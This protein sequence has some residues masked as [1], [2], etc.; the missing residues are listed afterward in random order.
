MFTVR[1]KRKKEESLALV[2]KGIAADMY[3]IVD[4][5]ILEDS[6]P[7]THREEAAEFFR[8]IS[9]E[10][11]DIPNILYEICNELNGDTSWADIQ[12]YAREIIPI[13]RENDPDSVILVGT[14]DFDRDL[15][16]AARNPLPFD[17]VMYAC[18]FYGA[19][20]KDA[21]QAELLSAL[22]AGLP[23]FV[24]ECG[25]SEENGGGKID[26]DSAGEW[27]SMLQE[28]GLSY[29]VWSISN[30]GES[31]ALFRVNYEPDEEITDQ[32]LSD[33]GQWVRELI[34]GR[35]P[36]TI[37][38]PDAAGER[39]LSEK[40]SDF[41]STAGRTG[42]KAVGSWPVMAG[43]VFHTF[44][45]WPSCSHPESHPSDRG[46]IWVCGNAGA[47]LEYAQYA[48]PSASCH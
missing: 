3:V 12:S 22:D 23:V 36:L 30:K 42:M 27:F 39:S 45:L 16:V 31:S 24:T 21:L 9:E 19:T 8:M 48:R 40:F 29:T 32:S 6:N 37:E 26:P 1:G 18:H 7:L 20:H 47:L 14:P 13:I 38:F 28:N 41:I 25:L 11:A 5:H 35:D 15:M 44:Q 17:Q 46:G 2:E 43:P 10:Y 4:W 34:R 33:A